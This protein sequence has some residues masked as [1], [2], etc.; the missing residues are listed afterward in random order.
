MDTVENATTP[1]GA[2]LIA[3]ERRRQIEAEGYTAEHDAG[4][5]EA[6]AYAGIAYAIAAVNESG[7]SYAAGDW[8]P[9][10][11]EAWKPTGDRVRDLTKAG[12]LIAA[13]ID[14]ELATRSA[15]R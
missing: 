3:A 9:W 2:D 11:G 5:G 4:Q 1:T 12:A 15:E 10:S 7:P 6:I 14:A 8:W 13:A